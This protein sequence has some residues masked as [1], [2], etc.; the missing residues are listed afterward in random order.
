MRIFSFFVITLLTAGA[1]AAIPDGQFS[2]GDR[3]VKVEEMKRDDMYAFLA[4]DWSKFDKRAKDNASDNFTPKGQ[5][6]EWYLQITPPFPTNWPPQKFRSVT[7]YA[8]AEYQELFMHGPALSRS[9][10]WAKVVLNEGMPADKVILASTIG[11]AVNGEGGIPISKQLAERKIRIIK[12]GE[13]HLPNFVRWTAIPT[14]EAE[15]TAIRE[16]YC[17][18]T[19]TNLTADLIKENHQAFFEWLSCPPRTWIPVLPESGIGATHT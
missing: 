7:Y 17:Q 2:L 15:V 13:A 3:I 10:P 4:Q 14:D 8:Y 11:P 19:L 12:E 1:A 6:V 18:W 9:A 5:S 16:Y